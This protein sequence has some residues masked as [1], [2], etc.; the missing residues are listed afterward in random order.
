[1]SSK[2]NQEVE[3]GFSIERISPAN[4]DD[5]RGPTFNWDLPD[6]RIVVVF[7]RRKGSIFG[8]HFHKGKDPSKNPER[9]LLVQG[10]VKA[11][12]ITRE[13]KRTEKIL[14]SGD[15]LTI[16]PKVKHSMRA[17]EDTVFIESRLTPFDKKH[18]DTFS[19]S[20]FENTI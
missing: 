14:E 3:Q 7:V 20:D 18:P 13:D 12:F 1:L 11:V 16:Y 4:P 9:F 15:V 2:E 10:K 5:P 19:C 8:G 6:G 17:L